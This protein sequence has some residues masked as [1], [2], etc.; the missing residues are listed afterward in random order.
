MEER[1]GLSWLTHRLGNIFLQPHVFI[2]F[3]T[4]R[5]ERFRQASI[6][7]ARNCREKARAA[8]AARTIESDTQKDKECRRGKKEKDIVRGCIL[9]PATIHHS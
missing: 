1:K 8:K 6:Y 9:L 2:R 5:G 3:R 7:V 4:V